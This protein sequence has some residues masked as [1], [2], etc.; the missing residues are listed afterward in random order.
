MHNFTAEQIQQLNE[1]LKTPQ[2]VLKW[3]LDNLHPKIAMASSFGAEDVVVIDMMMKL[4]PK[5]RIFTL[6]TGRLNQETYDVMDEIRNKYNMNIEV[7]FPD[8]NEVEE[9]VRVN[10]MNL[11]YQSMGNRKLCCGI[12]K[13]HP[14]KKMLS[15]VDGWIT[16]LRADQTEVRSNV[17]RIEIDPQHNGII[18]VNPIIEWTWEQTWDYIKN[19][20]IPYN[21]LHDKGYPSIGCEPCTRAIKSGEPLRAGRWWWETDPQKECGLHAEHGK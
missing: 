16:G 19:N 13:V 20:N 4:N 3:A 12:R 1:K 17:R 10:G 7:M 2:D 5:S 15:T 6:D 18:K 14:L 11:F 8:S 9:M 21:K